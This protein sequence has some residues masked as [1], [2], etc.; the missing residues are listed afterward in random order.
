MRPIAWSISSV[1]V[2]LLNCFAMSV[3]VIIPTSLLSFITGSLRIPFLIIFCAASLIGA[4]GSITRR[5]VDIISEIFVC[6][7]LLFA[8]TFLTKS[9]S[10]TIPIDV[11]FSITIRLLTLFCVINAAASAT[12]LFVSMVM[13][14][15]V[16][17]SFTF[18]IN[19]FTGS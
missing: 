10:V 4:S 9:R 5:G 3:V 6:E 13:T 2:F 17:I 8:R 15:F 16:I 1:N 12:V 7:G 18:D 14:V 19:C 11:L